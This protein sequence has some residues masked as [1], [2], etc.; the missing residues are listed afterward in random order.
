MAET[1]D[2]AFVSVPDTVRYG[3]RQLLF[4]E[5]NELLAF[6]VVVVQM[7]IVSEGK[8]LDDFQ[9]EVKKDRPQAD[10]RRS[11]RGADPPG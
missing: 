10:L 11:H 9:R 8:T 6:P 2:M 4:H 7:E 3:V 5:G 1:T